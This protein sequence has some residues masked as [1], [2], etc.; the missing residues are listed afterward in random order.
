M[1]KI[2]VA[3]LALTTSLAP[4]SAADKP[5]LRTGTTNIYTLAQQ[6]EEPF[7]RCLSAHGFSP[8]TTIEIRRTWPQ[9]RRAEYSTVFWSCFNR[10]LEGAPARVTHDTY[11][12]VD[13]ALRPNDECAQP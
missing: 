12:V 5:P 3:L 10:F 6:R 13:G 8:E 7:A 11:C 4:S 9:E 1:M 2:L